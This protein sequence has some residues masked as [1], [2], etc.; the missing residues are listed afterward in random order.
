MLFSI[1]PQKIYFAVWIIPTC[2]LFLLENHSILTSI[3][4]NTLLLIASNVFIFF[5]LAWFFGLLGER[6]NA[7]KVY[8]ALQ[9]I[10]FVK[11]SRKVYVLLI[12][13]AIIYAINI[14]GSGGVPLLWLYLGDSRTYIDFGL[15]TLGGLSNML[16][17]FILS[18]CYII[19]FYSSLQTQ[20]KRFYL[21][22]G[23]FLIL[24]ALLL[25]TGRGNFIVLIL[26]PVG[27]YLLLNNFK[28]LQIFKWTL[29]VF[30]I[31][32]LSG[33]IQLIRY[34]D[35][36]NKIFLY[37]ESSGFEDSG[38]FGALII[39]SIMYL[40]TPI[41]NVD[42]NLQV[43][44]M[45]DFQ[46]YYSLQGFLPT[47]IREL[48]FEQND[49]GELINEANNA[50]SYLTPFLRDFGVLGTFC[51]VSIISGVV[52]YWYA[53][54]RQGNLFFILSYPPI[55]MSIALSF[56]SLFFTS[57]VVLLYPF[58]VFWLLKGCVEK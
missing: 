40:T 51:F 25:E 16:R 6:G 58:L 1:S 10:D 31:F 13:W 50:T 35:G 55:F 4:M 33:L 18:S 24:S 43:A 56:F 47:I 17:A 53:R 49:Y 52:A 7:S 32:I 14:I 26:H 15:P 20:Q 2:F 39:P 3:Q 34:S 9:R 57:L 38:I 22:I 12:L 8:I 41:I 36:F 11:Y 46:P 5:L 54:S 19:Y 45:I 48:I 44:K 42:L 30:F 28:I 37:A 23:I 21:F 29:G 27:L